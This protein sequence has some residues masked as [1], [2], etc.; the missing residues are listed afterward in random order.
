MRRHL[1]ILACVCALALTPGCVT[2]QDDL[3]EAAG[4]SVWLAQQIEEDAITRE[5]TAAWL[6]EHARFLRAA[7]GCNG[8]D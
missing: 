7:G 4:D 2:T 5:Q 1:A 8:A 3:C 6:R